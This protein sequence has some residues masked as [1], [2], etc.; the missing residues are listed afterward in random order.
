MTQRSAPGALDLSEKLYVTLLRLYPP[1][2]R[3]EWGLHMSRTFRDHSREQYERDGLLG[4]I[5]LWLFTT[6]D[7]LKTALEE[8]AH[9]GEFVMSKET[10]IRI[11]S[12]AMMIGGLLLVLA[13]PIM[14]RNIYLEEIGGYAIYKIVFVASIIPILAGCIGLAAY[15]GPISR[16]GAWMAVAACAGVTVSAVA[17]L[18]LGAQHDDQWWRFI[19]LA[20]PAL[21][22]A[23]VIYGIAELREKRLPRWNAAPLIAGVLFASGLL[24]SSVGYGGVAEPFG[25]WIN[26][27]LWALMGLGWVVLG[28]AM[29]PPRTTEPA[30]AGTS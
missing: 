30:S 9:K 2:F 12:L 18:L 25:V 29:L 16:A 13:S 19:L 6:L 23:V 28:Y 7:V 17:I 27:I 4:L 11:G 22:A 15:A 26:V 1:G 24:I 21:T 14:F 20:Y 5:G 8:R 3:E 10:L